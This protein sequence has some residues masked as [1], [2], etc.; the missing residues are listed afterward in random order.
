[1]TRAR[2]E[3]DVAGAMQAARKHLLAARSA[4]GLWRG[5]LSSS[6]L[7]TAVAAFALHQ[8]NPVAHRE[9]VTRALRWLADHANPD[10]GWGDTPGSPSNLSTTILGWAALGSAGPDN[11]GLARAAQNARGWIG[12]AA[13]SLEPETLVR[14]V[15]ASYGN[16]RTFSAP[17][18]AVCALAGRLGD[19]PWRFVPQLPFELS[20]LPRGL[21]R[22]AK[23]DVVSYALPALISIGL[24]RHRRARHGATP[25]Q[26]LR[27]AVTWSALRK[28]R[29]CQPSHGGFLEA[30]PLNGFVAAALSAA[31][32]REHP[33]TRDCARFLAATVRP[34]GSWPID[35]DLA[36]W[37]TA[38]S[39]NALATDGDFAAVLSEEDRAALLARLV[40]QQF[41]RIHPF[42]QSPPGGW[43]WTDLPGAVPDADDTSGVLLAL[44]HLGAD[45]QEAQAAAVK[46]LRWLLNMQNGDGGLPTFCRGWGRL[47]FDRSC[48]DIT[49]H[50]L[51]A[52]D[53]W[54]GKVGAGL[55]RQM[56][57]ALRA[58]VLYL[59]GAQQADGSWIPLWFGNQSAAGQA[60]PTYGTARVVRALNGLAPGRL[61]GC[62]AM[63]GRG[64]GWLL[65]A[66][67]TDGGW[68]GAA[69]TPSSIEETALA[70]AALSPA[71]HGQSFRRGTEW[72][73]QRTSA[74]TRFDPAPV[75]LYFARLWYSERLYPVIFTV[76]ALASARPARKAPELE[77]KID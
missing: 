48:P 12:K 11:P 28:L 35:T 18:L 46:G 9:I 6:A 71:L 52:I 21:F 60:N 15:V 73:V 34:D 14:A 70:V 43:G 33:V 49:A 66:Q 51:A 56:D 32:L 30:A 67:N 42:T 59:A 58:G 26:W 39:V 16:D 40:E 20:V 50:A 23:L 76:Q 10:G 44:Y 41:N 2:G 63:V 64:T 38:L 1:M 25:L 37:L 55:R 29:R 24:V 65:N 72:L 77:G 75:G 7:S 8:F 27:N 13:G 19:D 68:G 31:G 36:I 22:F 17:I 62:D 5:E 45:A 61:Y 4:D 3:L 57:D 74:G 53:A 69:G 47:P 54:H